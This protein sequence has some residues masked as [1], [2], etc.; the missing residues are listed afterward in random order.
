MNKIIPIYKCMNFECLSLDIDEVIN[1]LELK[2]EYLKDIRRISS[3]VI[4]CDINDGYIMV[5]YE[6]EET[7]DERS[8]RIEKEESNEV[9]KREKDLEKLR[10]L[11]EKYREEMD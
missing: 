7:C 2:I 9:R 3:R 11:K 8:K 4:Q 10:E 6:R 1:Y 5:E